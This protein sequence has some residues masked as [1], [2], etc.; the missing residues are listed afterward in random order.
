MP[1]PN[2]S[3][4]AAFVRFEVDAESKVERKEGIFEYFD[5]LI[6]VFTRFVEII[7]AAVFQTDG[8]SVDRSVKVDVVAD[9]H[10][11]AEFELSEIEPVVERNADTAVEIGVFKGDGHAVDV[12]KFENLIEQSRNEHHFDCVVA[13]IQSVYDARD[14]A[15]HAREI[16]SAFALAFGG[17]CGSSRASLSRQID[18]ERREQFVDIDFYLVDADAKHVKIG[19]EPSVLQIERN[20]FFAVRLLRQGYHCGGIEA[21]KP[22]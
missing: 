13:D 9:R 15:E 20:D 19:K 5:V 8:K 14:E 21:T 22:R 1:F 16:E 2:T 6:G 18:A 12:E 10:K 17:E 4:V 3:S 7:D 11:H